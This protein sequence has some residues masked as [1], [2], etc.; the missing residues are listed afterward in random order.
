MVY[1]AL[2]PDVLGL[3]WRDPNNNT[4][5][6]PLPV[7]Q[8]LATCTQ[9]RAEASKRLYAVRPLFRV[10]LS[11]APNLF[12]LFG[13]LV[14]R[15]EISEIAPRDHRDLAINKLHE[16][17]KRGIETFVDELRLK[18]YLCDTFAAW[19]DSCHGQEDIRASSAY[20]EALGSLGRFKR[21]EGSYEYYPE[22][23][24]RGQWYF[25]WAAS[26]VEDFLRDRLLLR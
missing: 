4:E 2:I 22:L 15:L 8:L 26:E 1:D 7:L 16:C 9:I 21:F 23:S 13:S 24:I 3:D 12:D 5:A 11:H 25:K 20:M 19:W 10:K 6:R 18:I 17:R 14:K